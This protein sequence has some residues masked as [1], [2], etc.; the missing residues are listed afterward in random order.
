MAK[1]KCV[2]FLAEKRSS[3]NAR[4]NTFTLSIPEKS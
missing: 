3:V 1:F 2:L 4:M